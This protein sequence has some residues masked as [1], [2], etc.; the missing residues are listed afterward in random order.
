ML[1]K[2]GECFLD[3]NSPGNGAL[4]MKV[5]VAAKT[6]S[7]TVATL[8]VQLKLQLQCHQEQFLR[9]PFILQRL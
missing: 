7:A 2:I 1:Y 9:K 8:P 6:M 4:K 3:I 5:S